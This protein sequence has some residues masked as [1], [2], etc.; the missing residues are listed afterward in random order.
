[1]YVLCVG[2]S[3]WHPAGIVLIPVSAKANINA[4]IGGGR[5]KDD[6]LEESF[7]P[8]YSQDDATGN[9]SCDSSSEFNCCNMN[10]CD[11]KARD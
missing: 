6:R 1:M 7:L 5:Y 11:S 3:K 9:M 8:L 4:T 2:G 10:P